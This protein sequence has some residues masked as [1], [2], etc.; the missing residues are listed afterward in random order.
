MDSLIH[1]EMASFATY[2]Q[3]CGVIVFTLLVSGLLTMWQNTYPD[4]L[5]CGRIRTRPSYAVAEYVPG[6]LTLRQN[7]Y[8]AFLRCGRI[9]IW[10]TY[11][12]A[13]YVF[14]LLTLLFG[15]LTLLLLLPLQQNTYPAYLRFCYCYHSSRLRIQPT[16]TSAIATIA[17]EYDYMRML[18][19]Y[20]LLLNCW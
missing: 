12:V 19:S 1:W 3:F 17:A 14:S 20:T 5:C 4:F 11:A 16:Y 7:T 6:L 10:P 8:L 15:P 9:C 2:Y 18:I 13:E